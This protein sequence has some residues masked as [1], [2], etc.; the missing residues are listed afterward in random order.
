MA[1]NQSTQ[2]QRTA[3]NPLLIGSFD[4]TS[5]RVLT[6]TLGALNQVVG[7]RDTN[8][9]SN[10][11][12]GGGTMNHWFQL[13]L[14]K[15]AWIITKK[16]G[17][18]PN[19][20]AVSAYDLNHIPVEGRMI[21][22]AD[23]ISTTANG[24]TAFYP[25]LG[26][27]MGA[28]SALYN[29]FDKLRLDK[30]NDLYFPLEP[31]SYL[32]CVSSTRNEILDYTLGLVVEV[33]TNDMFLLLEDF[34]EDF[35]IQETT[36]DLNNTIIIGLVFA[37]D[38]TLA[39]N[40]NAYTFD[41]AT[42]NSGVTVTIPTTSTWYVGFVSPESNDKFSLEGGPGYDGSSIHEHSLTEWTDAWQRERSPG[43][44][45]PSLFVPLVNR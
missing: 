23:S 24:T 12:H 37:S 20:I 22:Q 43:D 45:L 39:T 19:Y 41:T 42:I 4:Q 29:T 30:G 33:P 36:L 10:G 5:L 25:Y 3:K 40:F 35:L 14:L 2:R 6:G 17:P 8:Q 13:N 27:V 38:Y 32:L 21:F 28:G 9:N 7:Y 31:G 34:E 44:P 18:R 26:N 16:S 1:R 11:G 15:S